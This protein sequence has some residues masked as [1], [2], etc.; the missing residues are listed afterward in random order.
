MGQNEYSSML[1]KQK[2]LIQDEY[3]FKYIFKKTE[4][5]IGSVFYILNSIKDNTSNDALIRTVK[6]HCLDTLSFVADSLAVPVD[7]ASEAA[8]LLSL[9]LVSLESQLRMLNAAAILSTEHLNVFV[10]E[11]DTALRSAKSYGWTT[12]VSKREIVE[13]PRRSSTAVGTVQKTAH[14]AEKTHEDR[15]SRILSVLK[16][17]PGVSIK[18]IVDT[19][20]DCSEKTIQRELNA[21]IKDGLVRREGERRWSKYSVL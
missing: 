16:A 3:Y 9:K 2:S 4:K 7:E 15:R 6:G 10:S 14:T 13:V 11:I 8:E 19:V 17:Q 20:K 5:I 21:L 12:A 18:D 1:G